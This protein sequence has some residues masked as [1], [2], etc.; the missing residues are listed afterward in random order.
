MGT[1]KKFICIVKFGDKSFLRYHV[2][3]L[4][5]FT[6]YLDNNHQEW[7]WYNVYGYEGE[8]KGHQVANFT[9]NKRP[10]QRHVL[11]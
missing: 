10:I 8:Y 11:L 2:S 1:V 5:K 3:D 4:L 7:R 6:K 9:K